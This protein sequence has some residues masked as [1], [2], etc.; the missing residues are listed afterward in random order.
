MVHQ[1]HR[2][3]YQRR[4]DV[5]AVKVEPVIAVPHLRDHLAD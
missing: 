2:A 4:P 1:E 3:E 5:A